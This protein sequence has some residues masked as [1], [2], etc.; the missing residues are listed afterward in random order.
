MWS[1]NHKKNLQ[2]QAN[3]VWHPSDTKYYWHSRLQPSL[4]TSAAWKPLQVSVLLWQLC[5]FI[6]PSRFL[7]LQL[8]QI[9]CGLCSL[10]MLQCEENTPSP[11]SL[12][13][14][15]PLIGCRQEAV[16][17]PFFL[18][19]PCLFSFTLFSSLLPSFSDHSFIVFILISPLH[20]PGAKRNM[21]IIS[22]VIGRICQSRRRNSVM[23]R[24]DDKL[25]AEK[26][27]TAP[28]K[29]SCWW[30]GGRE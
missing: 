27:S 22:S 8:C 14:F 6:C 2:K 11:G 4:L 19:A 25:N 3:S 15:P 30:F 1:I 16:T 21:S 17:S 13:L 26:C 5:C 9:D 23:Q 10:L 7:C 29:A 12:C 28:L 24:S 18:Q 20:S